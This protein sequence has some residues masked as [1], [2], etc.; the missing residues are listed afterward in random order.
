[1]SQR[2][3]CARCG[4]TSNV[5]PTC[6]TDGR[7]LIAE[8][9]ALAS[10]GDP[11][12]GATLRDRFIPVRVLAP[13]STSTIYEAHDLDTGATVV[14]KWLRRALVGD[15]VAAIA[16]RELAALERLAGIAPS[17]VTTFDIE[18]EPV[19][20]LE[21][22]PGSSLDA[23]FPA[24]SKPSPW[25]EVPAGLVR[26]LS[27]VHGRG[28]VHGDVSLRNAWLSPPR[29]LRLLDFGDA[30]VCAGD[31]LARGIETDR[32]A[33]LSALE[34]LR[35]RLAVPSSDR[36]AATLAEAAASQEPLDRVFE[37]LV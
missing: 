17:L 3:R 22:W 31:D 8:V 7:R 23:A 28:V 14:V 29:H 10:D 9:D 6:P 5:E 36:G 12:L 26:A 27:A 11:N 15:A 21:A 4:F 32:V 35:V 1:M 2:L 24:G 18:S 33:L 30:R 13:G 16:G 25:A 34:R 37:R 19:L 20:V